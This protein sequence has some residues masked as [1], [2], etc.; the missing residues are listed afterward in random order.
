MGGVLLPG[1]RTAKLIGSVCVVDDD[2]SLR[3][4]VTR[5]LSELG[6]KVETFDSASA[7]LERAS[8]HGACLLLLDVSMPGMDG[9]E[10]VRVL[11]RAGRRDRVVL[12]S[13]CDRDEVH[14][15]IGELGVI[16]VVR[17]PFFSDELVAALMRA[18]PLSPN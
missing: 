8:C 12:M 10:L 5:L 1:M 9:V 4:S 13:A 18:E 17:K 6:F 14:R 7:Y 16:E 11:R 2:A 3:T 15:R